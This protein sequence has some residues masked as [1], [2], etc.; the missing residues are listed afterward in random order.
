MVYAI[1]FIGD[2]ALTWLPW[3]I[4]IYIGIRIYAKIRKIDNYSKLVHRG[5][6]IAMVFGLIV[7]A[8]NL[9]NVVGLIEKGY[10]LGADG[11]YQEATHVFDL[12]IHK[13]TKYYKA[14]SGRANA[15]YHLGY[16]EKAISDSNKPSVP[17]K[18]RHF[19]TNSLM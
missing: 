3:F 13:S 17:I 18:V 19:P 16:Y 10:S 9:I 7:A 5:F 4:V 14:F 8:Y 11:K 12:A 6:W 15:Y 1:S 2:F